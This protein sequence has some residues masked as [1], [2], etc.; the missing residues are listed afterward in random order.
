MYAS[1]RLP[2]RSYLLRCW[3]EQVSGP[4]GA[5]VW[6]FSLQEVGA[7]GRRWGFSDLDTL[8]AFLREALGEESEA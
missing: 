4:G 7:G 5:P 6:R 8:V 3:Q 1:K 2:S